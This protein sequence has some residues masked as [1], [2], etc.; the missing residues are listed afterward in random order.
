MATAPTLP[1]V[2]VEE[3]LKTDYEP[4]CEYL[5][6]VL[7]PKALPDLIH[8]YLQSLLLVLIGGQQHTLGLYALA[9]LHSRITP[10]RWRLPDVC[11]MTSRPANGRY[12]DAETPP[13]FSIE[14]VSEGEPWTDLRGKLADHLAMGIKTVII[15]DPYNKTV[16][17][18]TRTQPLHEISAPLIVDIEVPGKG[19]LQIDFDELYRQIGT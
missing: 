3:Y 6:G 5:D 13:L 14:I 18:A 15:A 17:V 7:K 2:S 11:G 1:F 16:L 4:H 8:S 19:V 12:P 9:E 10:S